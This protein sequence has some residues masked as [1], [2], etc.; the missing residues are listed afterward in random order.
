MG[1][2]NHQYALPKHV[3][4]N[5]EKWRT[6]K[7]N[8]YY[9]FKKFYLCPERQPCHLVCFL[10]FFM[11]FFISMLQLGHSYWNSVGY[12]QHKRW[13]L[14]LWS[15]LFNS[16]LSVTTT[17]FE[18]TDA[19]TALTKCIWIEIPIINKKVP[20]SGKEW[21][22]N[23]VP[24]QWCFPFSKDDQSPNFAVQICY[25]SLNNVHFICGSLISAQYIRLFVLF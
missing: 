16:I 8:K 19:W 11:D 10:H 20:T 13:K 23:T 21:G 24:K 1:W 2:S 17:I 22:S 5:N 6:I 18:L 4:Q 15:F 9:I 14:S 7:E 12:N 3:K 25:A